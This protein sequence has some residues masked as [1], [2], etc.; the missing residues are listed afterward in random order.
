MPGVQPAVRYARYLALLWVP[1]AF[2]AAYLIEHP[3]W[4]IAI[5]ISAVVVPLLLVVAATL[6]DPHGPHRPASDVGD[7]RPSPA[8]SG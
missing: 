6:L 2:V 1:P 7:V 3:G 8:R 5:A 4:T